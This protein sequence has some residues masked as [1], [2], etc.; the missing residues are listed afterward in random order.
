MEMEMELEIV[1]EGGLHMLFRTEEREDVTTDSLVDYVEAVNLH[2]FLLFAAFMFWLY[3][4]NTPFYQVLLWVSLATTGLYLC[5]C[6]IA[7]LFLNGNIKWIRR[8]L[9]L[10][11]AVLEDAAGVT[12]LNNQLKTK[13]QHLASTYSELDPRTAIAGLEFVR[14][15]KSEVAW[16]Q[17]TDSAVREAEDLVEAFEK[18]GIEKLLLSQTIWTLFFSSLHRR[19]M[20]I[21]DFFQWTGA[22]KYVING[23]IVKKKALKIN[24]CRSVEKSWSVIRNL[25]DRPIEQH[26]NKWVESILKVDTGESKSSLLKKARATITTLQPI[27]IFGITE[28]RNV[29][30]RLILLRPFL[31]LIKDFPLES[32]IERAWL[33]KVYELVA[34][35]KDLVAKA[36]V[37]LLNRCLEA[38]EHQNRWLRVPDLLWDWIARRKL[39]AGMSY[40][41]VGFTQLFEIKE[42]YG[43]QFIVRD[44]PNQSYQNAD[45]EGQI[46]SLV[47]N[48]RYYL[49]GRG[50]VELD[51]VY[52]KLE[53]LCDQLDDMYKHLKDPSSNVGINNLRE[54]PLKEIENIARSASESTKSFSDK[55]E[56][57][58]GRNHQ[59]W[60]IM[61]AMRLF[62]QKIDQMWSTKRARR[63]LSQDIDQ[64]KHHIDLL[65]RSLTAY[66]IEL[67]DESSSVVGLEDDVEAVISKLTADEANTEHQDCSSIRIG[68]VSIIGMEGVGKTTLAKKIY[69]LRACIGHFDTCMWINVPGNFDYKLSF[70]EDVAK[71]ILVCLHRD[72]IILHENWINSEKHLWEIVAE[73]LEK[74][75]YFLVLDNVSK[76]AWGTLEIMLRPKSD[77][78]KIVLTTRSVDFASVD[79]QQ[80]SC[81]QSSRDGQRRYALHRLRLRTKAESLSLL[82]Q[83]VNISREEE[84]IAQDI[85]S[86]C[87]GLPLSIVRGG[88]M[89]LQQGGT[90]ETASKVLD[91]VKK[92][93][94]S[95]KKTNHR[96]L[97]PHLNQFLQHFELLPRDFEISA[98][99]L[100][101]L[102]MS[103]GLVEHS[104]EEN[105]TL[106]QVAEERLSDLIG[107]GVFQMVRRKGSG[108]VKTCRLPFKT[109]PQC[110]E[111]KLD[112]KGQQFED[113][114]R[115]VLRLA[116]H[117]DKNGL[118]LCLIRSESSSQDERLADGRKLHHYDP[119]VNEDPIEDIGCFLQRFIEKEEN[120]EATY[121]I[122]LDF[123]KLL[124]FFIFDPREGNEPGETIGNFLRKG[125]ERGDFQKLRVLDLER[126]FRPELPNCIGKLKKL[127][128]LGLRWTHLKSI[129]S[130]IGDLVDLETLDVKHTYLCALPSSVRKLQNLRNLY[131][132][133]SNRCKFLCQ[134]SDNFLKFQ[135]QPS[136]SF[137]K[138]LQTLWGMCVYEDSPIED[139]LDKLTNIRKLGMEL[140]LDVSEQTR[141]L[142]ERISKLTQ[143]QTLRLRSS[144][145]TNEGPMLHLNES[146]MLNLKL[147]HLENLTSIE[148]FG[149]P[150]NP[151]L[152][153]QLPKKL[154]ELTLSASGLSE[155][156]MLELGK[157][158][159]LKILCFY[160]DS[161]KGKQ[162]CC[163]KESFRQLRVLKLWK[164]KE[165]KELIVQERAL[166]NLR[167]LETRA[168]R[169]M[170]VPKGL[171]NLE[172][173]LELK[174]TNMPDI[175]VR[176]IEKEKSL[177]WGNSSHSP[178]IIIQNGESS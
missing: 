138:T 157:L 92:L 107:R 67:R 158:S 141:I 170:E 74:N 147:S 44:S 16:L 23:R 121:R 32:K 47:N 162:M 135:R 130:S 84:R 101:T 114:S 155:D 120:I 131:L 72:G 149:M 39:K 98:R 45:S 40:V 12:S 24:I 104:R 3:V 30:L 63:Q 78:S 69:S 99:R 65:E 156:A 117:F 151:A 71:Q 178:S 163:P 87:W 34:E 143:L 89:T 9:S 124:S 177:I 14:L 111:F 142:S 86:S 28:A 150:L 10:F 123:T 19:L 60:S 80:R 57:A 88:Y 35:A 62:S 31:E 64:I 109:E 105:E 22:V 159:S 144:A 174:V 148:L 77:W 85:A 137:L 102:W 160:S 153:Q 167:E 164:L 56:G 100:V 66:K 97:P 75:T 70:L 7:F 173:L 59:L 106:E 27:K 42:R 169:E 96:D 139:C 38:T 13:L 108:K 127:K 94:S 165:L 53:L 51:W 79:E 134:P 36:N 133:R 20:E 91:A 122:S 26:E 116:H 52:E 58:S 41:D 112:L 81:G 171:E 175:F 46:S 90:A 140:Q 176:N 54:A 5:V 48:I 4:K 128:Y 15:K 33:K 73:I 110:H 129:P 29:E 125:I 154:T 166:Q 37:V 146:Q 119:K 25:L 113:V 172:M 6:Y 17:R 145:K 82:K 8:E 83:M 55:F 95:F 68:I 21:E 126:A 132:N 11:R 1:A 152:V 61:P 43:F 49:E 136:D 76:E 161:Y 2:P 50:L 103:E 168:C 115:S 118:S 18:R 93:E